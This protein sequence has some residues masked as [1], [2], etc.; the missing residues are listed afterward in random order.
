MVG[1]D[2]KDHPV[3]TQAVPQAEWPTTKSGTPAQAAQAPSNLAMN[4]SRAGAW[5][6]TSGQPMPA[7]HRSLSKKF[8]Q[9]FVQILSSLPKDKHQI[10]ELPFQT[11]T[12]ANL[13][14]THKKCFHRAVQTL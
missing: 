5:T 6:C 3:L 11:S 2:L 1:K 13:I 4:I 7:P 10:Q 14:L 9:H 12:H 8:P